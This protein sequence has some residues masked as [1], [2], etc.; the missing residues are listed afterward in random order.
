[1]EEKKARKPYKRQSPN[2]ISPKNGLISY[3]LKHHIAELKQKIDDN[4]F[5][6]S[7]W[8]LLMNKTI[9]KQWKGR[10][11]NNFLIFIVNL[12]HLDV[13]KLGFENFMSEINKKENFNTLIWQLL[14]TKFD[15][16]KERKE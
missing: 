10:E 12:L 1:M 2:R 8:D 7:Q 11:E 4:N 9:N 5:N 3:I 15:K 13:E 16:A 6:D 14:E